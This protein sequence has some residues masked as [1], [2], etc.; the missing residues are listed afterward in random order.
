MDK[1]SPSLPIQS[2]VLVDPHV[3]SSLNVNDDV[4]NEELEQ[5]KLSRRYDPP[6]VDQLPEPLKNWRDDVKEIR[7]KQIETGHLR[8][9]DKLTT[10]LGQLEQS[11]E[12]V[13]SMVVKSSFKKEELEEIIR[14]RDKG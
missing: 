13:E 12:I 2:K 5:V 3:P 14:K 4:F 6:G 8:H 1:P 10:S 11:T 9:N 7:E